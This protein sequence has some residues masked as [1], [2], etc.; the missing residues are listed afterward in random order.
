MHFGCSVV[1][2]FRTRSWQSLGSSCSNDLTNWVHHLDPHEVRICGY[3]G[4]RLLFRF[5]K[6]INNQC[7]SL[8]WSLSAPAR[9][10][11]TYHSRAAVDGYAFSIR[12]NDLAAVG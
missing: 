10:G 8:L 12:K 1:S 2:G 4:K 11:A 3:P 6:P 9:R 5:E 7:I